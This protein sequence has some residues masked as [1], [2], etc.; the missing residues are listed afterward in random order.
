MKVFALNASPR[1]DGNTALLINKIFSTLNKYNIETEMYQLAGET[2]RGCTACRT[3]FE[4]K[5]MQCVF[6]N[7][8]LNE[9][10]Q[11]IAEADGIIFGSPT[12][13]ADVTAEM[14]AI[15]DRLGY[16]NKANGNFLKHKVGAGVSAV[17]RGGA[18]R[19]FDTFNHFFLI[20]EMIVPG[21]IYWNFAFGRNAGEVANDEEGMRTM[22]ALG[23]NIAWIM[24]KI[25]GGK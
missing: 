21:S 5:N 7:D 19:V 16:V 17:R 2:L 15:I 23:E 14:K 11:K 9:I 10:V 8:C 12:Y 13:F 1:K 3:C 24:K 20:N 4:K 6:K 18:N 22:E 25:G